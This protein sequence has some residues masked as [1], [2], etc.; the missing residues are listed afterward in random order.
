MIT[1]IQTPWEPDIWHAELRLAIRS[2]QALLKFVGVDQKSALDAPDF[3]V[4]VPRG[5]AARMQ[6]GDAQDPLLRQVLADPAE[7]E[8]VAGFS[9]DPL[10]ETDNTSGISPA[11]GL[12]HKYRGRAKPELEAKLSAEKHVANMLHA[13]D[14]LEKVSNAKEMGL[15]HS[16]LSPSV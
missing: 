12:I 11:P 8:D 2:S 3:P 6:P 1:P 13:P 16:N 15:D 14:K 5:F 10:A 4:L 9:K 7:L